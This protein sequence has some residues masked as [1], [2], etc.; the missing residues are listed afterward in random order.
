MPQHQH[1]P[2]GFPAK[3]TVPL[4]QVAGM[5]RL[6]SHDVR[7]GLNSMDLQAAYLAELAQTPELSEEL[8]RLRG[9]I[10]NT[11][12]ML[13]SFSSRFWIG[14]PNCITY[15]AKIF[16]EDFRD[17]LARTLPEQAPKI[18]WQVGLEEQSISVDIE[19]LF[20]GLSEYFKNAFHFAEPDA[21]VT[22]HVAADT[23]NFHLELR[24]TKTAVA[25]DPATWG[26]EPLVS[27]RRGGY[28]LGL[29]HARQVLAAHHAE[30]FCQHDPR[31]SLLT[32]RISLPLAA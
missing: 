20:G 21:Q 17:R 14:S 32:T 5:V 1:L 26:S 12:K 31:A 11:A 19:M 7:N 6:L 24:E 28:G 10:M 27:T 13:Q 30:L 8:K 9:M 29:F 22:A 2:E 25:S 18:A 23:Q 15:S 3:V 16:V 4:E